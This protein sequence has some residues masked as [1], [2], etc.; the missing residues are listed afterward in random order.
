MTRSLAVAAVMHGLSLWGCASNTGPQPRT[1]ARVIQAP[2]ATIR[3]PVV[4]LIDGNPTPRQRPEALT[5]RP[6]GEDELP[7]GPQ[8]F[9]VLEDG[10][11]VIAD[12]LRERLAVYRSDGTFTNEIGTNAPVS[13][14]SLA[15]RALRIVI[16]TDGTDRLID[17]DGRRTSTAAAG[18]TPPRADA[19]VALD[20]Q[21]SL[22]TIR[23]TSPDNGGLA[24]RAP[25]LSV[26]PGAPDARLASLRVL[27]GGPGETVWVAAESAKRTDPS[28]DSLGT[29]VRRYAPNGALEVEIRGTR[30][31][32]YIN[33]T[34]PFR[35]SGGALYQMVP[36]SGQ[37]LIYV[38][39]TL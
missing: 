14:V 29:I 18:V 4:R 35:V 2:T 22:G 16:A 26:T 17:L 20:P 13:E 19:D 23:W 3:I 39:R 12:P 38:W 9:A 6:G 27:A 1:D 24:A 36:E 21:R 5:I 31:D 28:L 34:T 37:V 32:Y 8:S 7:E 33:P 10:R 25:A 15:G 30:P 11:L